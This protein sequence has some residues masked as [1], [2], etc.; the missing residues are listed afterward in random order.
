MISWEGE[1]IVSFLTEILN[2]Y[3]IEVDSSRNLVLWGK[4]QLV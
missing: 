4:L 2:H 3:G 1:V